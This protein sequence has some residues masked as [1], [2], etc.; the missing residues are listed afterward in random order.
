MPALQLETTKLLA[1]TAPVLGQEPAGPHCIGGGGELVGG[2]GEAGGGEP[3]IGGT[4]ASGG[5]K[6]GE[7]AEEGGERAGGAVGLLS[8]EHVLQLRNT[9]P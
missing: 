9:V 4:L 5:E 1:E 8:T 6:G 2:G 7:E 3:A